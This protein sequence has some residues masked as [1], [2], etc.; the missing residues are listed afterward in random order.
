MSLLKRT[1]VASQA[2]FFTVFLVLL[3]KTAYHGRD[4]IAYPV[5]VFLELDPLIAL[6]TL[7]ASHTFATGMALSVITL[8]VTLVLGRVFCGWFCPLGAL[9]DFVGSFRKKRVQ[10]ETR[11]DRNGA[12]LKY[13]I[14]VGILV[15]AFLGFHFVGIMDPISLTVRS[16]S[17]G[18]GPASDYLVHSLFDLLY[19]TGAG[20]ITRVSEPTY[21]FLRSHVISFARPEFVQGGFRPPAGGTD[22][23]IDEIVELRLL[24]RR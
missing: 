2:V 23:Q 17:V 20:W 11:L 12:K 3:A 8:L 16:V 6:T 10:K 4:E 24:L 7:A 19:R 5:K 13:Y 15:A 9:N 1:R 14:L 22:F 18:I 21:E